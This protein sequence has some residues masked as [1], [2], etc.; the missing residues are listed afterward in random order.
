[1]ASEC[2]E[3][4]DAGYRLNIIQRARVTASGSSAT[5]SC[6]SA[7]QGRKILQRVSTAG[8][9]TIRTGWIAGADRMEHDSEYRGG[10]TK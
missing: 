10:L 2:V 8:L 9:T 4:S 1:M 6:V 5:S 7:V 3:R